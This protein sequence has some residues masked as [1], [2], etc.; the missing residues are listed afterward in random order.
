LSVS[1]DRF[2]ERQKPNEKPR[3][4]AAPTPRRASAFLNQHE[5]AVHEF[6][7]RDFSKNNHI[8]R[9]HAKRTKK[10]HDARV[11]AKIRYHAGRYEV[12][13][14]PNGAGWTRLFVDSYD[15]ALQLAQRATRGQKL[16]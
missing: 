12:I 16:F 15:Q 8:Y 2:V 14:S 1:F 13:L 9:A 5:A 11:R 6:P 7:E 10:Y 4:V 3:S